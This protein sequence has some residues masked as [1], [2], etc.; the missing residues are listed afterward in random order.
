MDTK[1]QVSK[2]NALVVLEGPNLPPYLFV[3]ECVIVGVVILSNDVHFGR[4]FL[5]KWASPI[6]WGVKIH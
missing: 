1:S 3:L 5:I 4:A 6:F 2:W